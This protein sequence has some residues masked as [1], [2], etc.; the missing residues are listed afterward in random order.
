MAETITPIDLGKNFKPELGVTKERFIAYF[1]ILGFKDRVKTNS[2]E[3]I[4]GELYRLK[5]FIVHWEQYFKNTRRFEK[6]MNE[7]A[8]SQIKKEGT[9]VKVSIKVK[10]V[11]FEHILFS[12][13]IVIISDN[14][15]VLDSFTITHLSRMIIQ[16][17]LVNSLPIKGCIA[18][19]EVS[20]NKKEQII[21][22]QAFI[23]AYQLTEEM[24]F[25]G[26]I[27]DKS[28]DEKINNVIFSLTTKVPLKSGNIKHS[29]LNFMDYHQGNIDAIKNGIEKMY[30]DVNAGP[31][32]YYDNTVE[33]VKLMEERF[34]KPQVREAQVN[35]DERFSGK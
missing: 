20:Y 32:L 33:L 15:G 30:F 34:P 25:M 16:Y 6:V 18:K 23:D 24:K 14:I 1:D 5:Q 21:F 3:K 31:R 7:T 22:G 17:C 12:D 11:S 35:N 2:H 4:Y 27:L 28:M 29:I 9:K 26:V 13:S 19:G 10:T 8:K